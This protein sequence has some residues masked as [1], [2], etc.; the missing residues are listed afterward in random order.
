MIIDSG[1]VSMGSTRTYT[2]KSVSVSLAGWAQKRVRAP[3]LLYDTREMFRT[4]LNARYSSRMT[5]QKSGVRNDDAAQYEKLRQKMLYQFLSRIHAMFQGVKEKGKNY[6]N[7]ESGGVSFFS[8]SSYSYEETE[9][10]TFSTTGKVKCADGREIDFNIGLYMGRSFS[11]YIEGS[12]EYTISPVA[13]LCDPLVINLEGNIAG[14]SDTKIRF[15]LDADGVIDEISGLNAGSGYLALD[16]NDDGRI[17]DGSELFGTKSGDGFSDLAAYDTDGNGWIDEAD[18]IFNR[19][20]I[21][22]TDENG[23]EKLY[24]LKDK[25]VGAIYLGNADTSFDLKS[26]D[27]VTNARIRKTGV[28]LYENGM[29]GTVQHLDLAKR[30]LTLRA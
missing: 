8:Y 4:Q 25:G 16:K 27:N 28:F 24:S 15:D 9:E 6:G 26:A 13:A 19:L 1:S 10:T 5:A 30:P 2:A 22:I 12:T 17:N 14:V 11:E 7:G 18:P 21:W 20:K 29:A 3:E 23:N